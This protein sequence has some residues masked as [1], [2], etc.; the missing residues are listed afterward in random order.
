MSYIKPDDIQ[1]PF[2]SSST[3]LSVKTPE[4]LHFG[5]MSEMRTWEQTVFAFHLP[6]HQPPLGTSAPRQPT[7]C[8]IYITALCDI[9]YK[10][11]RN[12]LT[13]LLTCLHLTD[14]LTSVH[15]FKHCLYSIYSIHCCVQLTS[16]D[17]RQ[18]RFRWFFNWLMWPYQLCNNHND[19]DD[20]NNNNNH[21]WQPSLETPGRRLTCGWRPHFPG[22]EPL[23]SV[24]GSSPGK[25]GLLPQ[26]IITEWTP[27]WSYLLSF[28]YLIP[29]GI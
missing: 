16:R 22:E 15:R 6:P 7:T 5:Q 1:S 4:F 29:S 2:Y 20:D 9:L 28:Q 21:E 26:H 13:Y 17:Y 18:L 10:R 3:G 8:H 24:S 14:D 27:L 11:L 25:C 19:D 12:T 23:T